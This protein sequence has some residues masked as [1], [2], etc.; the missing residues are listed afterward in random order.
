LWRGIGFSGGG[1]SWAS[2][3]KVIIYRM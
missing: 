2:A 1:S 3:G